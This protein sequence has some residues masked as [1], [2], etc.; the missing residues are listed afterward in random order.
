MYRGS[1]LLSQFT[2]ALGPFY[3]LPLS[4]LLFSLFYC[5]LLLFHFAMLHAPFQF[6]SRP[7]SWIFFSCSMQYRFLM[8]C[9]RIIICYA[10]HLYSF[11]SFLWAPLCKIGHTPCFGISPI[12]GSIL[13]LLSF[14]LFYSTYISHK[15]VLHYQG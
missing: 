7:C 11:Y 2:T 6:F 15:N 8:L 3:F 14:N 10:L 9:S 12:R 5:S 1:L 13:I 4:L